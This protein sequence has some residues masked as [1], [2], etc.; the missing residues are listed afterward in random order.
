MRPYRQE[1]YLWL[2]VV[3]LAALPLWALGIWLGVAAGQPWLPYGVE[4][5]LLVLLGATPWL[6]MQWQRP[7]NPFAVLVVSLL[8]TVLTTEQRQWLRL[9]KGTKTRIVAVLAL[10]PMIWLLGQCYQLA[11]LASAVTPIPNHGLG[12]LVAA[13]TFSGANLF[14]QVAM[15]MVVLLLLTS[16]AQFAAALPYEPERI[17][18]DFFR[19]GLQWRQILP[20]I[21]RPPSPEPEI[22]PEPEPETVPE[23]AIAEPEM[24]D[25]LEPEASEP[26][27]DECAESTPEAT[28]IPP[29]AP[30]P[31]EDAIE[32]QEIGREP[33]AIESESEVSELIPEDDSSAQP[34]DEPSPEAAALSPEAIV[35]VLDEPDFPELKVEGSIEP[36]PPA[37]EVVAVESDADDSDSDPKR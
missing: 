36:P 30:Q 27:T 26:V 17:S 18:T 7:F 6:W 2:H 10:L 4:E 35:E 13:I 29:E 33:D 34:D 3:G 12:L 24:A 20:T 1:P 14:M 16:E 8:P 11:P 25:E 15:S 5:T 19:F 37:I 23:P 32:Q 31:E 22:I 28:D 21:E 9:L